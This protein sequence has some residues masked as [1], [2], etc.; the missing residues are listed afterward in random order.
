MKQENN[1]WASQNVDVHVLTL[2]I[3]KMAFGMKI[4]VLA[5]V[6]QLTVF[7]GSFLTQRLA[8]ATAILS[9]LNAH[10]IGR[11]ILTLANVNAFKL[12]TVLNLLSGTKS[13]AIARWIVIT[14]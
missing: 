14:P 10:T 2:L 12:K 4:F 8:T 3:V 1:G 7:Q 13:F 6:D 5:I 11:L 9:K